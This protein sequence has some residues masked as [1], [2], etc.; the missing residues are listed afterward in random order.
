MKSYWNLHYEKQNHCQSIV[1][2]WTITW[3]ANG[4]EE[5]RISLLEKEGVLSRILKKQYST[6]NMGKEYAIE[7]ISSGSNLLGKR[8]KWSLF[9]SS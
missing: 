4:T 7:M 2:E 1:A 8:K 3:S 6:E 5:T 9:L